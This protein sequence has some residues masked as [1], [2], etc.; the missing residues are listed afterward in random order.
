MESIEYFAQIINKKLGKKVVDYSELLSGRSQNKK[1][2]INT[3]TG[4]EYLV[5]T[6]KTQ[7][8]NRHF[9]AC[10]NLYSKNAQIA[11]P[12]CILSEP[13]C[14]EMVEWVR[15]DC[16]SFSRD[17]S[18]LDSIKLGIL[19]GNAIKSVHQVT[20]GA[21]II[22]PDIK[23]ELNHYKEII[24]RREVSF[25]YKTEIMRKLDEGADYLGEVCRKSYVHMD[26]HSHNMVFSQL[27]NKI[28]LIDCENMSITDPWRDF[29]YA[30]CFHD[31]EEN[32]F[33]YSALLR[34]FDHN[35]PDEFW[36]A[37]RIYSG[38]QIL[39]ILIHEH[40]YFPHSFEEKA[41]QI[42]NSFFWQYLSDD[43]IKPKWAARI[44]KNTCEIISLI[45]SV[46]SG[47]NRK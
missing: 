44:E 21:G 5:R 8:I 46:S 32:L 6:V 4:E 31:N 42:G 45:N 12:V 37:S 3:D 20:V 33:W 11:K 1:Y 22:R 16:I 27:K 2:K 13:E 38:I 15:G 26:I 47:E 23:S 18:Y 24:G 19:A 34:Y 14:V 36:V 29:S 9:D 28:I 40:E 7:D 10:V 39:R 41:K 35:I 17:T 43:N 30:T 25:S